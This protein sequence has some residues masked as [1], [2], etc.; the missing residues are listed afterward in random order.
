MV[1]GRNDADKEGR[2]PVDVTNRVVAFALA[3][4]ELADSRAMT[5]RAVPESTRRYRATHRAPPCTAWSGRAA[6]M[7]PD[8]QASEA[9]RIR[10][11]SRKMSFIGDIPRGIPRSLLEF[12]TDR[13]PGSTLVDGWL[14]AC[15]Q[16]LTTLSACFISRI[17]NV[18]NQ[19]G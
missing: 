2:H 7:R 8:T 15:Q 11:F 14:I 1:V 17:D 4:Q 10:G 16:F 19:V 12:L 9:D 18:V 5:A 6:A 3:V 13:R